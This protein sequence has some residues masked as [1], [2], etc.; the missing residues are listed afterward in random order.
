[1]A[2]KIGDGMLNFSWQ[3]LQV[4]Q[5]RLG[6]GING[7]LKFGPQ[8]IT[9][10]V[11]FFQLRQEIFDVTLSDISLVLE[12]SGLLELPV[13]LHKPELDRLALLL[14]L[15]LPLYMRC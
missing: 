5:G 2:F 9:R 11:G 4:F 1:M 8:A 3:V 13:S 7:L 12:I 10:C 14:P 15:F 6:N